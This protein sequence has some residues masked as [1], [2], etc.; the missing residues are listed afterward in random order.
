MR[1]SDS[2]NFGVAFVAG[3]LAGGLA[4]AVTNPLDVIKTRAQAHDVPVSAVCQQAE[5][6]VAAAIHAPF[7][8][9]K[10]R[11]GIASVVRQIVEE[12]GLVRG[13]SAGVV[14]RV[15]WLSTVTSLT[16]A[17]YEISRIWMNP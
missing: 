5:G 6:A 1:I 7:A 10:S 12:E 3:G 14:P 4:A 9:P 2:V 17:F 11:I 13:M 15:V 16:F 8:S